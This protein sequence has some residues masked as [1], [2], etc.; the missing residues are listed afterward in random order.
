MEIIWKENMWFVD[1][2]DLLNYV[3][4]I[5]ENHIP[6]YY[7]VYHNTKGAYIVVGGK[8]EYVLVSVE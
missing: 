8:R 7:K 2:N 5:D 4:V 6:K 3:P 1:E